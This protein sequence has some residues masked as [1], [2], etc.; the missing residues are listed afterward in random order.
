MNEELRDYWTFFIGEAER[1][2]APLYARLAEGVSTHA[3]LREMADRHR[4]GQPPATMLFGAV[5]FH[6]LRGAEHPLRRFYPNLNGGHSVDGE[7][8][9]PA[10]VDFVETRREAIADLVQSRVTN[11]NEVGR[12]AAL[13]AGFRVLAKD[14]GQPLHLVEIGPSA[15]LNLIWDRYRIAYVAGARTFETDAANAQLTIPCELRGENV[16][17]LGP[18]PRVA[19]RVGLELNPVDLEDADVRDWLKALVWPDHKARFD[20][21]A[22]AIEIRRREKAEIL[23]GDALSLLP[24]V[25]ARVPPRETVCVYHSMVTYQFGHAL[26]QSFDDLLTAAGVRRPVWRLS[27]EWA[28]DNKYP[29]RLTRYHDGIKTEKVLALCD[30]HGAWIEWSA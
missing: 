13:H 17:P 18:A 24:D 19:S 1:L 9:F 5:H 10:F 6:L 30:P 4:P 25:L 11:T 15:G 12:S 29:L 28:G 23:A 27:L 7:E 21:L 2:H 3:E 16:P 8:P 14:A 22:K 20:R 26:R